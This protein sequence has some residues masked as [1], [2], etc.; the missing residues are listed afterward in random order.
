MKGLINE[1]FDC[2]YRLDKIMPMLLFFRYK[3]AECHDKSRR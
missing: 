1:K 2:H 3:E